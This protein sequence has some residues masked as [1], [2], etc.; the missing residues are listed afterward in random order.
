M[1]EAVSASTL[2]VVCVSS[3]DAVREIVEP[4]GDALPGRVL[5]N[6]TS[7]TGNCERH[8]GGQQAVMEFLEECPPDIVGRK[9][10]QI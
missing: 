3:Y 6:L 4:L 2:V 5:V 8:R 9:D 10:E 1:A 7:G